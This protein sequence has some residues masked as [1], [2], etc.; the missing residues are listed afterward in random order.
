MELKT[1][2]MTPGLLR[3]LTEIIPETTLNHRADPDLFTPAEMEGVFLGRFKAMAESDNPSF[4]DYDP[5]Q[6]LSEKAYAGIP[7]AEGLAAF[8]ARRAAT[9][10]YLRSLPADA[11]QRTGVHSLYGP[12]T[13]EEQARKL[14]AHDL[15]HAADILAR[16][17]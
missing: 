11:L 6:R 12:G 17:A 1:L 8:S 15:M 7:L 9:T 5:G 4:P 13:L 2:D 10:A 3:R 14:V 16:T